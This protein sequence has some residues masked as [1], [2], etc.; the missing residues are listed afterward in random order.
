MWGRISAKRFYL[1]PGEVWSDAVNQ[2]LGSQESSQQ[3]NWKTLFAHS[4]TA[5]AARPSAKWLRTAANLV[6]EYNRI[7]K[8]R[9]EKN[10][11][12][13]TFSIFVTLRQRGLED[14]HGPAVEINALFDAHPHWRVNANAKRA[15]K[16]KLYKAL[17]P[18]F[19][20]DQSPEVEEALLKLERE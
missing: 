9:A 3:R 1:V 20:Q 4:L 8:E 19:G 11:D 10:F 13:N 6:E 7:Q 16:T 2:E 15:L 14:P 12:P 18:L 5:T 17:L